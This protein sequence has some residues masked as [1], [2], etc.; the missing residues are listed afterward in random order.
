MIAHQA[1]GLLFLVGSVVEAA[2]GYVLH[3]RKRALPDAYW[4]MLRGTT[5]LLGLQIVAGILF[6]SLHMFPSQSLHFMYAALVTLTVAACEILR[7]KAALG[8]ILREEGHLGEAG[9]YAVLTMLS[10]LFALRLWM[11]GL[12]M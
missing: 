3:R 7:P 4:K 11:T 2:W 8:R 9:I 10:A 12:G 1:I 6:V 5:G